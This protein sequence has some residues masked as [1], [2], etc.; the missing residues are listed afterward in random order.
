METHRQTDEHKQRTKALK[1]QK[2]AKKKPTDIEVEKAKSNQQGSSSNRKKAEPKKEA[3]VETKVEPKKEKKAE[4][5]CDQCGKMFTSDMGMQ[6]HK[7]VKHLSEIKS[8][9][10]KKER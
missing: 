3:K 4:I 5:L 10:A 6:M 7:L 9:T 1:S 2:E 8:E